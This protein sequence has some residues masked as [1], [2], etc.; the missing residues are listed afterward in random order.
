[1]NINTII[2]KG[3]DELLSLD[4]TQLLVALIASV[5]NERGKLSF[6]RPGHI[7]V[8]IILIARIELGEDSRYEAGGTT[9]DPS[10]V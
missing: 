1:M 8:D 4:I 9:V 2:Q 6:A 3:F 7:D 10:R 5:G